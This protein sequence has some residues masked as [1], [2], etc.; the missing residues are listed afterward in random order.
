MA[1]DLATRDAEQVKFMEE[2]RVI[3]VDL[4]DNVVGSATKKESHLAANLKGGMGPHRAFSVIIFR[5]SDGKTL[6]HKRAATK[7]TFPG[8]VTNA[9]CSHPLSVPGELEE[10]DNAGVRRAAIRKLKH[11]LGIDGLIKAEDLVHCGRVYYKAFS[12]GIWGEHEV[13]HLLL[14]RVDGDEL[15]RAL[16]LNANEIESVQ[17]TSKAE[18]EQLLVDD[19]AGKVKVSPWFAGIC[20]KLLF[21]W[22]DRLDDVLASPPEGKTVHHL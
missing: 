8:I 22:W 21:G 13:D 6:L 18:M 2:E 4:E 12:D 11:E 3:M 15:D 1:D 19:A 20:R 9:C 10:K 17:W 7:V 14:V 16:D 5:K